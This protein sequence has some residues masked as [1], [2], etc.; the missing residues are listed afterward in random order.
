MLGGLPRRPDRDPPD[1]R[2]A[3]AVH[4]RTG[5]ADAASARSED[6]TSLA[7]AFIGVGEVDNFLD[8]DVDY[9][10]RLSC[11]GVPTELQVYPGVIHGGFVARPGTQ[12]TRQFLADAHEAPATASE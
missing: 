3:G 10:V 4:R 1:R 12:R 2:G 8:E 9:A 5:P 11:A 6:L 7:L